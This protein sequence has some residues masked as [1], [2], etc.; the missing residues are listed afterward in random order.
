MLKFYSMKIFEILRIIFVLLIFY[1]V[2]SQMKDTNSIVCEKNILMRERHFCSTIDA[3]YIDKAVSSSKVYKLSNGDR[4]VFGNGWFNDLY[5]IIEEG[6]SICKEKNSLDI[7]I[8]KKD[9]TFSY[10]LDY[11]CSH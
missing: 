11:G 2:F 6:D 10:K 3:K 5:Q 8:F 4:I 1:L 9:T 7:L